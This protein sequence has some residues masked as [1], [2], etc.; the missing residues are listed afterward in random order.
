MSIA[1]SRTFAGVSSQMPLKASTASKPSA[2]LSRARPV[3]ASKP[4]RSKY[5]MPGGILGWVT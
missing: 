3:V 4:V 1:P 5:P 2:K